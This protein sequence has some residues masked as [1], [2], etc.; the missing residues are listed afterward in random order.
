MKKRIGCGYIRRE[1]LYMLGKKK[2]TENFITELASLINVKKKKVLSDWVSVLE[3]TFNFV[4]NS[5]GGTTH[6][7]Y[8][9]KRK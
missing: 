4:R 8:L 9:S 6:S 5:P 2:G 7:H 3:I 1:G